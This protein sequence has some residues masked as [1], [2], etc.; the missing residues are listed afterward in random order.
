MASLTLEERSIGLP[1]TPNAS[2]LAQSVVLVIA[3]MRAAVAAASAYRWIDILIICP[4]PGSRR[5]RYSGR[6]A[7]DYVG[8]GTRKAR[9]LADES[10]IWATY[11]TFNLRSPGRLAMWLQVE[12]RQSPDRH[13]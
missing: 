11:N 3:E 5:T 12:E 7:G 9:V 8:K 10:R 2:V 13:L 1:I 6:I 4:L